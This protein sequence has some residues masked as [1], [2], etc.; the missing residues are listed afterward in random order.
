MC[1]IAGSGGG[2]DGGVFSAREGGAR[3]MTTRGPAAA[4]AAAPRLP[5]PAATPKTVAHAL[6][7]PLAAGAPLRR[8]RPARW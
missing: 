3:Y 4:G 1:A 6:P 8:S 7:E 5:A 2:G